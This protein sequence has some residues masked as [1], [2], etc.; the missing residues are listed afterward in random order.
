MAPFASCHPLQRLT[1]VSPAHTFCRA[2][3]L[4]PLLPQGAVEARN[5]NYATICRQLT[6]S[7]RAWYAEE[8]DAPPPLLSGP[9]AAS[10]NK[11]REKQAGL[12]G[13]SAADDLAGGTRG[14]RREAAVSGVCGVVW[15]G[16]VWCGVV[17]VAALPA[18]VPAAGSCSCSCSRYLQLS[19]SHLSLN[20][21]TLAVT[22]SLWPRLSSPRLPQS[23][24]TILKTTQYSIIHPA[25]TS[26]C[27][28][29]T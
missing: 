7:R 27:P 8:G 9:G 5:A 3:H 24:P 17:D 23:T 13:G 12:L 20:L 16:V 21:I 6:F 1:L 25:S 22:T 2:L 10:S 11:A 29:Q 14:G 26:L 18:A 4:S 19:C 15:C 28:L